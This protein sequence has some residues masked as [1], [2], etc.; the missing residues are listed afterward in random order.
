MLRKL[1]LCQILMKFGTNAYEIQL[2][3]EIGISP[4]F[5]IAD[6][7]PFKAPTEEIDIGQIADTEDTTARKDT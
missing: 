7:T 1:G 4:I 3:P 5:N 6:L 2:S